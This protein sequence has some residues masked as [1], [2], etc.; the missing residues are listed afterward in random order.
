MAHKRSMVLTGN[1]KVYR[2]SFVSCRD[3]TAGLTDSIPI[4][5]SLYALG[6][7]TRKKIEATRRQRACSCLAIIQSS[8]F[9]SQKTALPIQFEED[10]CWLD[11][12]AGWLVSCSICHYRRLT[13][14]RNEW[15]VH[16][17]QKNERKSCRDPPFPDWYIRQKANPSACLFKH[18][19]NNRYRVHSFLTS[20]LERDEWSALRASPGLTP[21]K[22]PSLPFSRILGEPQIWGGLGG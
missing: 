17:T 18:C 1:S 6:E 19:P 22:E 15:F 9:V 5:R 12:K 11:M 21:E 3:E 10:C 14:G 4:M 20:A 2:N 13:G 7:R 8:L 16:F